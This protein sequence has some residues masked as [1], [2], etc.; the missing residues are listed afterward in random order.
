MASKSC[1]A[2]HLLGKRCQRNVLLLTG[3]P[4][5]GK[6]TLIK[7]II[8]VCTSKSN[9]KLSG[10]Y[11]EESRG[12]DGRRDGFDLVCFDDKGGEDGSGGENATRVARAPLSRAQPKQ[13]KGKPFVGKYLVDVDN[14]D[15][16][17]VT[18]LQQVTNRLAQ[19][20]ESEKKGHEK[21]ICILDEVGKMELLCPTFLPAV[22]G[23]LDAMSQR[24][25]HSVPGLLLGTIPTP[26]YGRVI[27]AVEDI[28]SRENV[29]VVHV[30]KH[31][32][33]ELRR[34]LSSSVDS[35]IEASGGT[36]SGP[37]FGEILAEYT[38]RRPVGS[39]S[40]EPKR[41][42]NALDDPG[43]ARAATPSADGSSES[44]SC[45]PL[46]HRDVEPRILLLGHHASPLPDNM[47][48]AYGERSMW[49]ILG[50]IYDLHHEPNEDI[51][52]ASKKETDNYRLL[53]ES[54]LRD[55]VCI[56]DVL[57]NVHVTGK[58]RRGKPKSVWDKTP[59]DLTS[60]LEEHN[61]IRTVCFIG[62]KAR[63]EFEKQFGRDLLKQYNAIT[64]PSSSPANSRL[65]VEEKVDH[66]RNA[67]EK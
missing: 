17:G 9:V 1:A 11:T 50:R 8:D 33:D 62:A 56:W 2:A 25:E 35:W 37:D 20:S 7:A 61:S 26:R 43:E 40:M 58:R 14:V 63:S 54:V 66:W 64:L 30:T 53:V 48:L 19:K 51:K 13:I 67:I 28:R 39:G 24:D 36:E 42:Y 57:A 44:V 4:A 60:F 46:V 10:L 38:Y 18:S 45:S 34:K 59:N 15:R 41:K 52:S 49:N 12:A 65:T 16:F 22:H 47:A 32:R 27:P 5:V 6:T 3:E 23:V 29:P 21:V 31:N 55:G